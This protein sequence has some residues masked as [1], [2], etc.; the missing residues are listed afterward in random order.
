MTDIPLGDGT[1]RVDSSFVR[2]CAHVRIRNLSGTIVLAVGDDA[3]EL[4][5]TAELIWR[6]L[7]PGRRVGEVVNS[8]AGAY[9]APAAAVQDDVVDFLA[10][11][12]ARGFIAFGRL[13][14]E[15]A[16]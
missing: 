16:R 15:G 8:V 5:E 6:A 11:L 4:S 13:S 12:H 2:P 3:V 14:A 10:D 9:T 7:T 1:D